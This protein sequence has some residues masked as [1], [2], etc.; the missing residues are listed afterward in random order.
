MGVKI[1]D[2]E[3]APEPVVQSKPIDIDDL[4]DLSTMPRPL[5]HYCGELV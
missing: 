5:T 3:D 4:M 2:A 1:S